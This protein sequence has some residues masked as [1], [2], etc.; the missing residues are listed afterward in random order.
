M[1]N[2]RNQFEPEYAEGDWPCQILG[3]TAGE[4]S[5]ERGPTGVIAVRVNCKIEDGP[6]KGKLCTYEDEI[7]EK[8][9]LYI[10]RSLTAI[11]WKGKIA[12]VSSDVEAWIKETGGKSTVTIK[13]WPLKRGKKYDKWI[14]AGAK[15]DPPVWAKASAIGRGPKPLAAPSQ[16]AM[17][18]AEAAMQ[19]AAEVDGGSAPP[20]DDP[21]AAPP[22]GDDIPFATSRFVRDENGQVL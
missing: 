18:D 12:N 2:E 7:N 21:G 15:G 11:G 19:R 1:S 20:M 8:S 5:D 14:E 16:S 3:A 10:R 22:I 9:S 17:S 4:Q 13:H 6:S